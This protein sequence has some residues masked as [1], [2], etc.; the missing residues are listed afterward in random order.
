MNTSKKKGKGRGLSALFGDKSVSKYKQGLITAQKRGNRYFLIKRDITYP[1]LKKLEKFAGD[2]AFRKQ[3]L[4]A[5]QAAKA[6]LAGRIFKEQG[7]ELNP[8]SLF[9]IQV[10]FHSK[11]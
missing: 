10:R 4:K 1:Q 11:T 2:K 6:K 7:I 3:W 5:K 9:D 8:E